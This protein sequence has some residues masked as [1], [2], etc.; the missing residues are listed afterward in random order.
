MKVVLNIFKEDFVYLLVERGERSEK[1]RERN[2]LE[3]HRSVA[4][5]APNW[6]PGWQ[7]RHVPWPG[8]ELFDSWA[9]A[10]STEPHQPGLNIYLFFQ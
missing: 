8:V 1:E 4:S 9:G 2:M 7:P 6:G 3:I 10:Q 5:H